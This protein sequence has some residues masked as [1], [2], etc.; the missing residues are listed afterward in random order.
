MSSAS[1]LPVWFTLVLMTLT[2][3][4][5]PALAQDFTPEEVATL[6]ALLRHI[7]VEEGEINGLKG[8]HVIIE[9]ANVHVRSGSGFTSDTN[10][11]A[12]ISEGPFTG[13]G[14]V[15][16][17]YNEAP[18][19][20]AD[21]ERGGSHNVIIGR[22]HR[23]S[24]FAGF[25]A[26]ASNTVS[27]SAASVSG[28]IRNE[29]SGKFDSVSGGANNRASGDFS[30][31]SGGRGNTASGLVSSVSGGTSNTAS[32]EDSSVSG[33]IGNTASDTFS[34]V[35]GGE[36][37]TASGL[38]SSVS[39]G[40]RNEASGTFS[41]VSGG[42][43]NTASRGG[44][45]VSGGEGNTASGRSSSVSGGSSN[46]ASGDG[47][48][49]G[50]G[51]MDTGEAVI[52]ADSEDLVGIGTET[53][54]RR[55]TIQGHGDNSEWI[56][57]KDTVG[58]TQWHMNYFG[59]GLN[60]AETGVADFRLYLQDGGNVGIGTRT[61]SSKLDVAGPVRATDFTPASDL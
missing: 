9:G 33:G 45:S 31:V 57:F 44:S 11:I 27:G 15:V 35:S 56:S 34:S 30:S 55:L 8:P 36:L 53:P 17:G 12:F 48:S 42:R 19:D 7:R 50:G 6:K 23:Y 29:A 60:V 40:A 59:N 39:G 5:L 41:S 47:S 28:G 21:G 10:D 54:D 16:V 2:L 20:L 3:S 43:S 26:G 24:S 52:L 61:P 51:W 18:P 25:V 22:A 46:T 14:N 37:N 58:T 1:R 13:L 38:G 32:G 4:W 49:I